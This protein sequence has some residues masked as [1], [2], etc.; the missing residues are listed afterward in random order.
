AV[1]RVDRTEA[2]VVDGLEHQ[3]ACRGGGAAANAAATF[4]VPLQLLV[5]RIPGLQSAARAL[6]R[7][8]TE[9]RLN[10]LRRTRR[11]NVTRGTGL[12]FDSGLVGEARIGRRNVNQPR[13]GIVGHGRPVVCAATGRIHRDRVLV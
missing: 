6:W 2:A 5:Q 4:D 10:R 3:V 8:G 1:I 11:T 7:L 13:F 9:G 12:V